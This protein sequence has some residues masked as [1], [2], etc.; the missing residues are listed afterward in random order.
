MT[1]AKDEHALISENIQYLFNYMNEGVCIHKLTY[2]SSGKP[3]DYVIL[4][5]NPAYERIIGIKKE[6]AQNRTASELYGTGKPPFLEI[7]SRVAETLVPESFEIYWPPLM[8]HFIISVSSPHKGYF[9]TIFTDI[10]ELKNKE[11]EVVL[12]E[13]YLSTTLSSIGDAVI[14][15]DQH[16]YIVRMN[17]VAEDL[18]GWKMPRTEGRP[19]AEVFNIINGKTKQPVKNPV[20]IVLQ[21]GVTVGLANDTILISKDRQEYF[22]DDS[23]APIKDEDDNIIGVVLIFRDITDKYKAQEVIKENEEK[24]RKLFS[25]MVS[26]AALHEIICDEEGKPVDYRTLE[27]NKAFESF[28]DVRREDVIGKTFKEVVP[29]EEGGWIEMFGKVALTGE[30]VSYERY[31]PVNKKYFGGAA[32]SPKPGQFAVTFSDITDRKIAEEKVKSQAKTLDIIFNSA[33]NIMLLVNGDGRVEKINHKGI[34][35]AGRKEIDL[36]GLLGGEVFKCLNSFNGKGCGL[37]EDC[38]KCP[39]RM[40]VQDTLITGIPHID[41]EGRMKF[42]M[43][44]KATAL[45]L[46]ISTKIVESD[47]DKMV[48]LALTNITKIKETEAQLQQA[49]KMESIGTLAGGIAHDFNN[50]LS[51]IMILTEMAMADLPS[52]DPGH[53]TMKEIHRAGRRARDLV[54]Q[55]LTFARKRSD[56][57]APLKLTPIV[58]EALDFLRS[59]LPTTIDIEYS[60]K[61]ASDVI[62]GDPTQLSQIL[63]NLCTNA[64]YAMRDSGGLLEITVNNEELAPGNNTGATG[65]KP[66]KYVKLMVRDNGV[67]ISPDTVARIFEP[68]YTTKKIGEGTGLGL[69]TVHGIV[70]EYGGGITVES[71]IG[72]G[73]TFCVYLPLSD[74]E[75]AEDEYNVTSSQ[76]GTE[77]IL[78][79]DDEKATVKVI[80]R[81]L[82]KYGYKVTPMSGSLDALDVFRSGPDMF[83]LVITDMTMPNLTGIDLIKEIRKITPGFP[84]ILCTGFSD[85]INEKSAKENGINSFIMKPIIMNKMLNIIRE[86]LD[87]K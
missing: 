22:I 13:K 55:I 73:S 54:K 52:D 44:G 32:Y 40:R 43:N 9:T 41:E 33:P 72:K 20:D 1:I 45:D 47:K 30:S 16:G 51:P 63:M 14:A 5:V 60:F 21:S 29:P 15:T 4:D 83:D 69:A 84:A 2:D 80:Q 78:I 57:R 10:T 86:V 76:T 27:V 81:M 3:L 65:L 24:Y 18:T 59:T 56:E 25:E 28:L 12:R 75:S 70:Q 19:L 34:E 85:K 37:N 58:R 38:T 11:N 48:L 82:E 79:V 68:Y 67:G 62:M 50:I 26:G 74:I 35:F 8:K 46:L 6:D 36:I 64:A 23:A 87:N 42:V 53:I 66:G 7:Y 77:S 61:A 49:Q 71:R 31:S 39:I 17:S